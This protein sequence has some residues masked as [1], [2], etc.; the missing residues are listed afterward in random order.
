LKDSQKIKVRELVAA[1]VRPTHILA[2]MKND[3]PG[4]LASRQTIHNELSRARKEFLAG[5]RPVEALLDE[6]K[7]GQ[8]FYDVD[9]TQS[10]Q[11]AKAYNNVL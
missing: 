8:Y 5:R 6:L 2:A 11:L 7:D 1:G 3:S 10:V 9:I 4:C